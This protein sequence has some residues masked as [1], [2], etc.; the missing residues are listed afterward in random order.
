MLFVDRYPH[1]AQ[2]DPYPIWWIV[3]PKD[4][5]SQILT[6]LGVIP[7]TSYVLHKSAFD[8]QLIGAVNLGLQPDQTEIFKES[9]RPVFG[10][11]F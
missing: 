5:I 10:K 7:P 2:P 3:V 6:N 8:A 9:D 4:Y 11:G 1:I